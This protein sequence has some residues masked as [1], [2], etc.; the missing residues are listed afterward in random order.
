[1]YEMAG[2]CALSQCTLIR[3]VMDNLGT[4]KPASMY[5]PFTPQEARRILKKFEFQFMPKHGSWLDM[6]GIEL[7]VFSRK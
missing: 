3:V 6:A 4:H 5:E 2:G 1:M 7:S